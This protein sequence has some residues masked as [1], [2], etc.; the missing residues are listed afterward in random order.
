[1]RLAYRDIAA[2][3]P[4][5][6]VVVLHREGTASS[7]DGLAEVVRASGAVGRVVA[8]VGD[9]AYTASGMEVAGVCWYRILPGFAGTDPIS[10]AKA[11]VQ[12]C[13][14]LDDLALEQPAIIGCGQG[15]VV[16]LGAGLL[17][18]GTVG[19][20]ACVDAIPEHVG[21]LPA[22][23]LAAA[24]RPRVLLGVTDPGA[25][26]TLDGL[27]AQLRPH[28]IDAVGWLWSEEEDGKDRDDAL[29]RRIGSWLDEGGSG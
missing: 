23:A 25:G 11:V 10:L 21:L 2:G 27:E 16:A 14:L 1:M 28:G 12:V 15:G 8:P 4:G 9:Y 20:I 22:A 6:T 18:A 19:S 17:R 7:I 24:T 3:S 29:A 13:D 5:P 26:P